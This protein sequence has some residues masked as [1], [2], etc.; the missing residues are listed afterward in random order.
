MATDHRPPTTDHR[1]PISRFYCSL[2]T[3]QVLRRLQWFALG[4][5]TIGVGLVQLQVP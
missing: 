5:L 4:L 1:P 3:L 2:F